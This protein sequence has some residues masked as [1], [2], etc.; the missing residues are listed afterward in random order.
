MDFGVDRCK[1]DLDVAVVGSQC[2]CGTYSR[3]Q[4]SEIPAVEK[5]GVDEFFEEFWTGTVGMCPMAQSLG[6]GG[7]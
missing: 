4:L 1:R 6:T 5:F 2:N 7:R 3:F